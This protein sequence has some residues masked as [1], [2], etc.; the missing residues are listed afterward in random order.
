MVT[1]E[2]WPLTLCTHSWAVLKE[3]TLRLG[4]WQVEAWVIMNEPLWGQDIWTDVWVCLQ[5]EAVLTVFYI[6]AHK[7]LIPPG[8]QAADAL[9]WV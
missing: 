8:N 5:S 7:A 2:P 6:P 1:R 4:Q 3:F 9:A